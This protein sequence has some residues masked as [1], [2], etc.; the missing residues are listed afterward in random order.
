MRPASQ[1]FFIHSCIYLRILIISYLATFLG[2][3]ALIAFLCWCAV[4]QS[5]SQSI[6]QSVVVHYFM[7]WQEAVSVVVH[8]F[9]CWKDAVSVVV[10]Y[11]MC[12]Q[13]AVSV[14]LHYF[15]CWKD[16]VSV[17]VHYFMCW[18]DAVSVDV[19]YFMCWQEAVSVV[20]HYFMCWKDAV[21]VVHYFMCWQE[22]VSVVEYAYNNFANGTQRAAIASSF[23][24]P[25][26]TIFKVCFFLVI[27]HTTYKSYMVI[28][29]SCFL[30]LY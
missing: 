15:M 27:L 20:V 25:S 28:V 12:W 4:K 5:I 22:A 9:M 1:R 17:V 10:H 13:E 14:V 11:F 18:K 16:A 19:H 2:N 30:L 3:A 6:N 21:S 24:G 23:Y 7:C 29:Y 26:F 8:Y